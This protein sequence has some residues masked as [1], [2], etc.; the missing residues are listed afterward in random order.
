MD[1]G[2]GAESTQWCKLAYTTHASQGYEVHVYRVQCTTYTPPAKQTVQI[3]S[4]KYWLVRALW[5]TAFWKM[6]HLLSPAGF[7]SNKA[8]TALLGRA[9]SISQPWIF[10]PKRWCWWYFHPTYP[11]LGTIHPYPTPGKGKIIYSKLTF[12][13]WYVGSKE[14]NSCKKQRTNLGFITF[15][16]A[17]PLRDPGLG[18]FLIEIKGTLRDHFWNQQWLQGIPTIWLSNYDHNL[19]GGFNPI[20]NITLPC[21]QNGNLPPGRGGNEKIFETTTYDNSFL[22]YACHASPRSQGAER[23]WSKSKRKSL[24]R[25]ATGGSLKT[26]LVDLQQVTSP[27]FSYFSVIQWNIWSANLGWS[28]MCFLL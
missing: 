16:V 14:A 24:R 27:S 15:C 22:V 23:V 9:M 4:P 7:H 11:T 28:F 12:S 25:S 20:E 10:H 8:H 21:S 17:D 13:E 19:V 2:T 1:P 6:H 18:V 5:Y 3:W 26:A